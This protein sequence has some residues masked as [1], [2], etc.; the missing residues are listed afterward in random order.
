MKKEIKE[1][2][3]T[4]VGPSPGSGYVHFG[5]EG[6]LRPTPEEFY[7]ALLP[8]ANIIASTMGPLG[9]YTMIG[10]AVTSKGAGQSVVSDATKDGVTVARQIRWEDPFRQ[11]LREYVVDAGT[12]TEQ[13][14][15]DGT[16]LTTVLLR[17]MIERW[18]NWE[19]DG[20]RYNMVAVARAMKKAID[21]VEQYL[22]TSSEEVYEDGHLILERLINVAT[23]SSNNDQDLGAKIGQLVFDLNGTGSIVCELTG[24]TEITTEVVKGFSLDCGFS[25]PEFYMGLP[26]IKMKDPYL[27]FINES[28]DD[29]DKILHIVD[30]WLVV[31]DAQ[32]PLVFVVDDMYGSALSTIIRNLR[33]IP[34]YPLGVPCFVIRLPGHGTDRENM[35]YDLSHATGAGKV[36]N[37]AKGSGLNTWVDMGFGAGR[38]KEIIATPDRIQIRLND[39]DDTLAGIDRLLNQLTKQKE[40]LKPANVIAIREISERIS[41]ITTGVGKIGIG[42][43]TTVALQNQRRTVDDAQRAVFSAVEQGIQPGGGWALFCASN[44]L[45]ALEEP[46]DDREVDFARTILMCALR[47]PLLQIAKNSGMLSSDVIQGLKLDYYGS[48]GLVEEYWNGVN[49]LTGNRENLMESGVVDPTKVL[50]QAMRNSMSV[51]TQIINTEYVIL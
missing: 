35:M 28:V 36:Y 46:S 16:T 32:T 45:F 30:D 49:F 48:D 27:V 14:S 41:R 22:L 11:L 20:K 3:L 15:G 19:G 24:G 44:D 6:V 31:C 51:F 17:A 5:E 1:G 4:P 47:A 50:I 38:A 33:G 23:I 39:D 18:S 40:A 37:S 9:K 12:R 2:D 34:K 8:T 7:H 43:Q 10:S 29:Y 42:A 25:A 26:D 21:E 13:E